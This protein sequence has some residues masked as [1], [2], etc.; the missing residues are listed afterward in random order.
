M[1][2]ELVKVLQ[3]IKDSLNTTLDLQQQTL[4]LLK[5]IK[6]DKKWQ[7]LLILKLKMS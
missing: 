4:E 6:D 3:E 1:G 7:N 5:E 2:S